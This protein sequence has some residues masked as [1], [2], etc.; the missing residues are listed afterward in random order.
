MEKIEEATKKY[1]SFYISILI[2][3]D[4]QVEITEAMKSLGKER[5]S[6]LNFKKI[7]KHL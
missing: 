7:R 2:A 6:Q 1:N 4:G 5:C 3:Y